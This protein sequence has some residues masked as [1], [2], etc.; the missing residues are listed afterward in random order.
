MKLRPPMFAAPVGDGRTG[1]NAKSE[2]WIL[3]WTFRENVRLASVQ[4][5]RL[6]FGLLVPVMTHR[7]RQK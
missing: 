6:F 2:I 4:T 7:F 3:A 1:I 5:P